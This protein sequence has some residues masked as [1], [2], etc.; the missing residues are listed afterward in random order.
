MTKAK[1]IPAILFCAA[2]LGSIGAGLVDIV[3]KLT[4]ETVSPTN[5]EQTSNHPAAPSS[6]KL[7][8]RKTTYPSGHDSDNNQLNKP[9]LNPTDISALTNYYWSSPFFRQQGVY[10]PQEEDNP[11][12][13]D[14]AADCTSQCAYVESSDR[15]GYM[16]Y[17]LNTDEII[18]LRVEKNTDSPSYCN[19][20]PDCET[21]SFRMDRIFIVIDRDGDLIRS[22][23]TA[24]NTSG[25][26]YSDYYYD[27]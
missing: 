18:Q 23:M 4:L 27:E 25:L 17:D 6:Q 19:Q 12:F 1:A 21:R 10:L 3:N 13:P 15:S 22:G 14:F 11:D 26:S 20:E 2:A 8:Y 24:Y 5:L 9:L 16:R 7:N